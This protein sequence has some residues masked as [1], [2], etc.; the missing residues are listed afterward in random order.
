MSRKKILF[1]SHAVTM[2]HFTRPLKWIECLDLNEYDVT[3][4]TSSTFKNLIPKSRVKFVEIKCIDPILF[5]KIVDKANPIYDRQ[6]FAEHIL[7]DL[8]VIEDIKPDLVIGDFRHSLSVSCRV[9]KIKYINMTNAYWS[10]EIKFSHPMPEAPI[11]RW[12]GEKLFKS[13]L[14]LMTPLILRINFF[15]MTFLLRRSLAPLKLKFRDYRR[16]IIDGDLTVFCDTPDMIPLKKKLANEI[17]VGPLTWSMPTPLPAWWDSLNPNKP[18]I[19]V[20]M[21]SS[22]DISLMPMILT[23]LSKLDVEVVVALSGKKIDLSS[24]PNVHLA[25][26]LPIESVLKNCSLVICN[27]GSP[28]SHLALSF[29]VPTIGIV[30]NNDQVL[31]MAHVEDRG[32]GLMLRY[33]NVTEEMLLKSVHRI[34]SSD[35]F[36]TKSQ[37]IQKE[38]SLFNVP[39]IL[40]NIVR[41]NV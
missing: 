10:P 5:S 3:F 25:D 24:F 13:T 37:A 28:M 7:E 19:F 20:T 31:N 29:G 18:Q 41:D 8:Q 15:K 32:A 38:F 30:S 1:F 14:T 11:I 2:A 27:G 6:T 33:W 34:L 4:A 23:A 17:F 26:F 35:S 9:S 16:L 36:R 12:L 21:G 40:R 22:G 39:N